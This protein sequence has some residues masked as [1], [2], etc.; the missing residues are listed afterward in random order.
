MTSDGWLDGR[1]LLAPTNKEVDTIN[2]LMESWVP[3]ALI[4]LSSADTLEDYR[5]F[6]RFNTE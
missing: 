6:I 5:D 3:G 2:D 1:C 4:K